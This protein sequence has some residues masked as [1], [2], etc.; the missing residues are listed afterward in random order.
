[1]SGNSLA[2]RLVISSAAW[3]L[4]IL[5]VTAAILISLCRNFLEESFDQRIEQ[6]L[7]NL[8]AK[9]APQ[10]SLDIRRPT[11]LGEPL[12]STPL[13]GAYWQISPA[14]RAG[15]PIYKSDSLADETYKTP[16]ELDV[17]PDQKHVRAAYVT[18]PDNQILRVLERDIDFGQEGESRIYSI[19]V[20]FDT[21][22]V[23]SVSRYLTNTIVLTL[24]LLGAG[25]LL[26]TFFQ[27]RFGLSPLQDIGRQIAKIRAGEEAKLTGT[28]PDEILPLQEELNALIEANSNIVER[29]RTHVGNL[30]HALKT[31][32]SVI[33][34]EAA[35]QK[36]EFAQ[37]IARQAAIMRQQISHYLDRA[38]I[39]AQIRP[40]AGVTDVASE[41][42]ALSRALAKIYEARALTL[43]IECPSGVRFFG[44]K[45]DFE[46]MAG[47]LMDNACKWAKSSVVVKVAAG[48]GNGS[49]RDRTFE[50]IIED[51]GPGLPEEFRRAAVKR[52]Q[53]LDENVP[54]S[55]LGLSIVAELSHLYHGS[56][57]L[58]EAT[59]GG[60]RACLTLPAA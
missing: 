9:T 40:A 27:V 57:R 15:E 49:P 12:F 33:M 47:N 16:S 50:L 17:K 41:L 34:N 29:A 21:G 39:A 56:L 42:M 55:G 30:A 13:S 46:E 44:E 51:D 31:P 60:L 3:T 32:L 1:M 54:G 24:G 53:R 6:S 26:A 28:P 38:R 43:E 52:G 19:S 20:A 2:L 14:D 11:D 48:G 45:Q 4:M 58:E 25:L 35:S 10:G 7:E 37:K 59:G 22:T 36:G 8:I 5:S 18:G 23:E